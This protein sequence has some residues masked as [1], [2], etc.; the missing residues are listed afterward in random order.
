MFFE[1]N[2][3]VPANFELH[4]YKQIE[5]VNDGASLIEYIYK[6]GELNETK[7]LKT[8]KLNLNEK[9]IFSSLPNEY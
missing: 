8:L 2:T 3:S 1:N 4:K 9:V 5:I 6:N 7:K